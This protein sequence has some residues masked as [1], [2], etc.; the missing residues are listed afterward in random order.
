MKYSYHVHST[1]SDGKASIPEII[2]YAR[3]IGLDEIGISDHFHIPKD[4]SLITDDMDIEKLDQYISE[5]L[6]YSLEEKPKVKLGLEAEFIIETLNEFK[7]ITSKYPFDYI[8]GSSHIV[9]NIV[10]D[11]SIDNLPNN[12]TS[13]IMKKYWITIKQLAQS[14]VFDIVGHVDITK[15]FGLKPTMDLSKYVDDALEAIKDADMAIEVNTSG[16]YQPCKEQYPSVDILKKCKKLDIP[17][18]ITADAHQVENLTRGFDRAFELL[19]KIGYSKQVYFIK[20]KR[21]FVDF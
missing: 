13:S 10:I 16:W 11:S 12:Y 18:I 6:K 4:S 8:I 19:K 2:E 14:K 17:I 20:R 3:K 9:N 5:I 1:Y 7:K 21:F 15:K